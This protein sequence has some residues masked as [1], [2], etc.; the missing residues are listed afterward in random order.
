[1]AN[2][3]ALE[4][5]LKTEAQAAALVNDAQEEADRRIY[6]NEEK[7]RISFEE[8]YKEEVDKRKLLLDNEKVKISEL[9]Q[10][11]LDNYKEEISRIAANNEKFSILMNNLIDR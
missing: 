10:K 7:N 1:M 8:R 2:S 3:N 9:Y 6:E 11:E 5:L 4:H